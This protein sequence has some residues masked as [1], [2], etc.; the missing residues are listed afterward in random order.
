MSNCDEAQE[1]D[2]VGRLEALWAGEFGDAYT[3]RNED[4]VDGRRQPFWNSI[5]E[6][7]DARSVLEVGC[8]IGANL[9]CLADGVRRVEGVDVNVEALRR[10]KEDVP[11]ATGRVAQAR[12]LPFDD[13][14]FGLTFTMGVLIHQPEECLGEVM[15]EIVRCSSR[16]VLAGEYFALRTE[17]VHYRGIDGALFRRNYRDLYQERHPALRLVGEGFLGRG[18]GWDDLTWFLFERGTK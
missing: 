1:P 13:C 4:L 12:S 18:D 10:L 16:F 7:T 2:P 17:E 3:L 9:R 5:L 15:D 11:Y 14:E 8:N 6:A